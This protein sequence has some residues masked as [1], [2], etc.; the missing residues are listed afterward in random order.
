MAFQ[1]F[2]YRTDLNNTLVDRSDNSFAPLPPNTGEIFTDYFIPD[3]QPLFLYRESGGTIIHNDEDNIREY[4]SEITPPPSADDFVDYNTFTGYTNINA[5]NTYLSINNFNTYSGQTLSNINSRL[6]TTTFNLFTGTTAPNLYASKSAFELFTGT[7]APATYV[8]Y[9]IFNNYTGQTNTRLNGKADLSGATF[10]GIVRGVTPAINDSSTCFATTAYYT[11]QA[12]NTNPLVDGTVAIGTSLRFARQDHVHPTDTS[13]LSTAGG[14]ITGSLIIDSN[15]N[16]SGTTILNT[17]RIN[18]GLAKYAA[19]YHGTYD[20]RTLVDKEYV[21]TLPLTT[22]TV[23]NAGATSTTSTT[24][25]LLTG[26]ILNNVPA[27]TYLLNFGTSVQNN[28]NN[29][30]IWTNIYVNNILV[31]D[32]EMGWRRGNQD[33]RGTHNYAGYPI[34][35]TATST[36]EIRWRTSTGTATSRNR[37]LTLLKVSSIR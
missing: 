1:Y 11:G 18:S 13:R 5:P 8:N 21:D 33:N 37:N 26:M 32:T 14:T 4:I 36:V 12:A 28:T 7:T 19:N 3:I 29:T 17:L 22:Y 2:L 30:Q 6:L 16:V 34:T 23:T 10:T 31:N 9:T 27:G 25:T 35:L 15:L 20:T 24:D